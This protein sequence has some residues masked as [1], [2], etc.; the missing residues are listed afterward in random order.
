[1][2]GS[3]QH[4]WI[5][6][7]RRALGRTGPLAV[8]PA[9]PEIDEPIVRLVHSDIRLAELFLQTAKKANFVTDSVSPEE[10]AQRLIDFLKSQNCRRVGLAN[11]EIIESL[12][13]PAKLRE[14]GFDAISWNDLTLDE[15]YDLDCG[16]TDV[17]AAVAETGSLAIR[18]EPGNG[19]ALSLIPPIHVAIVEP[20]KIVADLLDLFEKMASD[21]PGAAVSLITGPSQT[22]DI[23]AVMVTGVHGPGLVRVLVVI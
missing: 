19:R 12:N 5:G 23:E 2:S 3:S 9:P 14:S 6:N 15:T 7:V 17:W 10:L 22:A 18:P 16:V 1:V 21:E 4:D 8:A 13:L 20:K 11:S